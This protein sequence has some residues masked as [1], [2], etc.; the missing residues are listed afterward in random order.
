MLHVTSSGVIWVLSVTAA[1]KEG[2]LPRL[3][4]SRCVPRRK[5]MGN[6][7]PVG[8]QNHQCG[9]AGVVQERSAPS[10]PDWAD[11]EEHWAPSAHTG[12]TLMPPTW[13]IHLTPGGRNGN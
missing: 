2:H 7:C 10:T 6:S 9:N 8:Q 4:G 11:G 13:I 3:S 1:D 12:H 5:F